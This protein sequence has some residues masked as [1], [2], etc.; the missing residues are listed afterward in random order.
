MIRP[1]TIAMTAQLVAI[2]PADAE[3]FR[4]TYTYTFGSVLEADVTGEML[5]DGE[6]VAVTAIDN[7][8]LDGVAGPDLPHVGSVAIIL[9]PTS[10]A[11]PV[12]TVSGIGNDLAACTDH[13]CTETSDFLTFDG[14][15]QVLGRPG[16]YSTAPYGDT[17]SGGRNGHESYDPANYSLEPM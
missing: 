1:F 9:D 13:P 4:L 7:V 2:A 14:I 8:T 15:Y 11:A 5:D 12:L 10:S 16:I 6:T 17:M 3:T